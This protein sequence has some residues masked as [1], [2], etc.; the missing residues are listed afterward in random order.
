MSHIG[1]ISSNIKLSIASNSP[2]TGDCRLFCTKVKLLVAR[3]ITELKFGQLTD[4]YYLYISNK[5]NK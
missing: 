3:K 2:C 4:N 5:Y 1:L